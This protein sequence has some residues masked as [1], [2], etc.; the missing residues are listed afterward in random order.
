MLKSL[1]RLKAEGLRLKSLSSS[2]AQGLLKRSV[3]NRIRTGIL[4]GCGLIAL[5]CL[6]TSAKNFYVRSG[7]SGANNGSDWN[8]AWKECSAI[9]WGG[10]SGVNAGDTVYFAGG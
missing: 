2:L 5:S 7:A 9:V 6:Q 3:V 10:T 8:N 4:L 1:L